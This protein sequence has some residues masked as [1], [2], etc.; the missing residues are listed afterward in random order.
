MKKIILLIYVSLFSL[1][2]I[3]AQGWERDLSE[4][5][6]VS[7]PSNDGGVIVATTLQ[8]V[9]SIISRIT[10]VDA[11]GNIVWVE[12][13]T[14]FNIDSGGAWHE[15]MLQSKEDSSF[16]LVTNYDSGLPYF[17]SFKKYTQ[18]GVL[19]WDVYDA[20]QSI[21]AIADAGNGDVF[22][23]TNNS[24]RKI[25]ADN[26]TI[27]EQ[28]YTNNELASIREISLA[29]NNEII[30]FGL[31]R[32]GR[33]DAL[34]N[35]LW[36]DDSI[37]GANLYFNNITE[38]ASGNLLITA[39]RWNPAVSKYTSELLTI[40]SGG[41][42]LST[43]SNPQF[44]LT[45][46]S[47]FHPM[48][49]E[50]SDGSILLAGVV[51]NNLTFDNDLALLKLDA[52]GNE[53]WLRKYG[54][55][56]SEFF[57]NFMVVDDNTYYLAGNVSVPG[58]SFNG[59]L[60]KIDSLGY[61]YKN[62]I[63]GAVVLDENENCVLDN[64]EQQL[65]N[66]LIKASKGDDEYV[67]TTNS[68]GEF[69]FLVDTGEYE[70]STFPFSTYWGLCDSVFTIDLQ[71]GDTI[72]QNIFAKPL[73]ECPVLDVSI[74]TNV[75]R[76]C[77]E[78]TY[79]VQYCNIGTQLAEDVSID[80]VL[81]PLMDYTG[82]SL[83]GVPIQSGDTLTFL[84]NDL[85]I[86]DCNDFEIYFNLGDAS[87]CD[88]IPIGATHCIEAH[89]YPDSICIPTQNWSG[90]SIEVDALCIGDSIQFILENVGTAPTQPGLNYI[91]VEDD[92][93]L[94]QDDFE[95][96][97]NETKIVFVPTN[98]STFRL[99]AQQ[100]PNHPGVNMPSISV[101]NCGASSNLFTFGFVNI[102]DQNDG[103][104]Y[105]DIDCRQNIGSFD[106]NDK[107]GFPLGHSDENIIG[108]N[109]E[110]EYLIRFQNTG[111]DTAFQVVIKDE[112]SEKLDMAT[113]RTGVS[114]HP[115]QFS[116][117]DDRTLIFN[118]ENI[119][120]PDSNVN[121]IESNGFVKFKISPKLELPLGT[122]VNNQAAIYFDFNA[123]I[124][125]NET[126]HTLGEE[127]LMVSIDPIPD[128][129]DNQG[130]I[131]NVFPNPFMEKSTIEV[132]GKILNN[133]RLKLYN[134]SGQLVK[135]LGAENNF[136]TISKNGLES[137]IYFFT[138][139]DEGEIVATGKI[140]KK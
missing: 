47:S 119:M 3:V 79:N 34:G 4:G 116:I 11:L 131:C 13:E 44:N 132:K 126:L 86:G 31:K 35:I 36:T 90:A 26:N 110:I 102:F 74:G 77:V 42:L 59:Y 122:I 107:T 51:R 130:I 61:S 55:S 96:D 71:S 75:L 17:Q 14:Y 58:N 81:D 30:V 105:I 94:F 63:K 66:W 101:E 82:S 15:S 10:K 28:T 50:L 53:V 1:T 127:L 56:G 69:E 78:N 19:V 108:L 9:D 111:T 12:E 140:I 54:Q 65:M 52:S 136:F 22:V 98:G 46:Y 121:L 64:G 80:L 100:E 33:L 49:N 70:L 89:I 18:E 120:L 67:T 103:N 84:L 45:N 39:Q 27:W 37:S 38:L 134:L 16:L 73:V 123:P 2:F 62:L 114:S 92:V 29:E 23:L 21:G 112:L 7:T 20:D 8:A 85:E 128:S 41:T 113:L 106:P 135:E 24:L 87:N 25:D 97:V 6:Q 139:E 40:S 48:V 129:K 99:E 95:L 138:I 76:R 43:V 115:Y 104:P 125:T 117:M 68:N 72:C 91:I 5:I 88:S 57:Q 83:P 93:V 60:I 109:Q 124:I 118:F 137:N 133:G 32:I